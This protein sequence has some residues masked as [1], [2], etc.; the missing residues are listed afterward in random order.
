MPDILHRVGI[1]AAPKKVYEAL[2]TIEGLSHWWVSDTRGEASLGGL[3]D[4]KFSV[5]KVAGLE[6]NRLVKWKCLGGPKEWVGTV[7]TFRLQQ[8]EG[9]VFILFKHAGWKSPVEFM[10]HCS[11]KWAVFLLSLKSWLERDEGRPSPYD[12]KIHIGD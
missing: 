1:K 12:V 10:H 6:R 9:Q 4:F 8:K 11:T 3:I 2:T 7:I 5:M